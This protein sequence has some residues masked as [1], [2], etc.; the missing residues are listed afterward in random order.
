MNRQMRPFR[1]N[2]L[3]PGL[4]LSVLGL[5][6]FAWRVAASR[7]SHPQPLAN[8][9]S[10]YRLEYTAT[11]TPR[12]VRTTASAAAL[13]TIDIPA[14]PGSGLFPQGVTVLP[15]GNIVAQ[16]I[17]FSLSTPTPVSGVGAV[18]LFNG[19]DLS[20]I[21]TLTGSTA[22]DNVGISVTVLTNG[23]FVVGSRG[24][25]NGGISVGAATWCNG[26][27]GCNGTVS[28]ANSIF[29][30]TAGDE[31]GNGVVALTNGN[32]VVVSVSWDNPAT[33][34]TQ[35]GAATWGN[36]QGGT[37]GLVSTSNS[38][39][40]GATSDSV[41]GVV[42]SLTNGNYIV[43]SPAWNNPMSGAVDVGAATWCNGASPTVGL[44]STSNS[45]V[46]GTANDNVGTALVALTNGNYVVRS[47]NWDNPEGPVANV[48]AVTWGNGAT[49][50]TGVVTA[51]NSL[52]GGTAEDQV[53]NGTVPALTNGNYVVTSTNWDNPE[54]GAMNAGAATWCSGTSPTSG[55]VSASN[56]LVG[57]TALD[58]GSSM[59]AIALTNGNYVVRMPNWDNPVGPINDVG[60]VA[61]GD[62][63]TGTSGAIS[64]GNALVGGA[65]GDFVGNQ[66]IFPL[67]N[68]HYMVFSN[69]W[70][71]PL[72][73]ANAG[74]VTLG[75]GMG[76]TV[77]LIKATN[78]VLG[79]VSFDIHVFTFDP[80]RNRMVVGRLGSG[81]VTLFDASFFVP[82]TISK[83]FA[84][85]I[86][87]AGA[88]A[89][90]TLTLSNPNAGPL[91][92]A[93]FTDTLTNMNAAG[94]AV[95]GTCTGTTP[96]SLSAGTT[97][98]SFSG[99]TI[100]ASGSCTVTFAVTSNTPGVHP[101]TTSGVT[102]TQTVT[103][104]PSNTANLTVTCLAITVNP[105]TVPAGRLNQPYPATT[106]SASTEI[107]STGGIVP[108]YTFL[109]TGT[110]PTGMSFNNAMLSG[111]PT[112]AGS[113]NFTITATETATGCTGAQSYTLVIKRSTVKADFDGDGKT[114]LSVWR[115]NEGNWYVRQSSTGMPQITF[116]AARSPLSTT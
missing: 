109:L 20:L 15:N 102:T 100:P 28:T 31:V 107:R 103:G 97:A 111:T 26:T 45:L 35:A 77:G 27:T 89:T 71:K 16:D 9:A 42:A 7:A 99:I 54:T 114:D 76:G 44:V 80:V 65:G 70:D 95:G 96:S 104:E 4:A 83:A 106:F 110:L 61:W 52:I 5:S 39:V 56:S 82:P 2:T 36:G 87:P 69:S 63:A 68:G 91:T 29:G 17:H 23:N 101:N 40:G 113:F 85:T 86:I 105:A 21:S 10:S 47:L 41:G 81:V 13:A 33:G 93:S 51:S 90:V 67:A 34:A 58:G 32:Y 24:W 30:G 60:A 112:Q 22:S 12:L 75:H 8:P 84:P 1:K 73:P 11:G 37:V 53:G 94:G 78:S 19:T 14:P 18:H 116:W 6:C 25:K 62:G 43:G 3:W 46:G 55:M 88:T 64:A 59:A 92:N 108:P 48:G 74:A 49:G 115:G 79:A 72:G 66:G 98:L 50:T 38:L 57:S